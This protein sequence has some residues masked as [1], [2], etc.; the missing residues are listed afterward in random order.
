MQKQVSTLIGI[1]IIVATA[2]FAFGGVFYVMQSSKIKV[3]NDS[4]KSQNE[5]ADWKTYKNDKYGFEIKYPPNA[6]FKA[7]IESAGAMTGLLVL[8]LKLNNSDYFPYELHI[9]NT[10]TIIQETLVTDEERDDIHKGDLSLNNGTKLINGIHWNIL[11]KIDNIA[12]KD[13]ETTLYHPLV[14]S[15]V[16]YIKNEL[17]YVFECYNC[18]ADIFNKLGENRTSNFQKMISTFKFTK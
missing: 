7:G 2:V 8:S 5:T 1:I 12:K 6:Y 3:Q 16:Y 18:N 14:S 17:F 10:R 9:G 15:L 13:A 4:V 11:E